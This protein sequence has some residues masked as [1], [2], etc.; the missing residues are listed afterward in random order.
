MAQERTVTETECIR[1][2]RGDQRPE[3]DRLVLQSDI[4]VLVDFYADWCAPCRFLHPILQRVASKAQH[5]VRV[6][7]VNVDRLPD[8]A[9]HYNIRGI[10]TVILFHQ[11][12]EVE[13]KLGVKLPGEY[14]AMIEALENPST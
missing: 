8:L 7:K 3:F 5:P 6:V 13:R 9:I 1:L 10:P 11:G 2:D 4:P 12:R 14:L